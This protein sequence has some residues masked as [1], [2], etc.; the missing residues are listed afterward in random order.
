MTNK[1]MTIKEAKSVVKKL[2][3][4]LE[5]IGLSIGDWRLTE[6]EN[7]FDTESETILVSREESNEDLSSERLLAVRFIHE[8]CH[9]L[10][11]KRNGL[12]AKSDS[13][14]KEFRDLIRHTA[15]NLHAIGIIDEQQCKKLYFDALA[16]AE[17]DSMRRNPKLF[18]KHTLIVRDVEAENLE[19]A[20]PLC[21]RQQG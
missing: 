20:C 16:F 2:V 9:Y 12:A 21:S 1:L 6:R 10:D 13:H 18:S 4:A 7:L 5:S 17:A 15:R 14:R 3:A 8:T 11:F 19:D